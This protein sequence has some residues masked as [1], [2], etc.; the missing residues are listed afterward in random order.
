MLGAVVDHTSDMARLID[1]LFTRTVHTSD[2]DIARKIAGMAIRHPCAS[3]IRRSFEDAM[4]NTTTYP[5][6]RVNRF[7]ADA[8]YVI[9][10]RRNRILQL[11]TLTDWHG[12]RGRYPMMGNHCGHYHCKVHLYC[13]RCDIH[14]C[15]Q[16]ACNGY[17][18]R[19]WRCR[20]P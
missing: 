12:P 14:V 3:L 18:I 20:C 5:G 17:L 13:S 6:M 11:W 19:H 2:F 16:C 7:I 10:R 8:L 4:Q 1:Q 9:T 15:E